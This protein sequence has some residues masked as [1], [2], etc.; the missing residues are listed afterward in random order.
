M[1]T[2]LIL[3]GIA[4]AQALAVIGVWVWTGVDTAPEVRDLL[5]LSPLAIEEIGIRSI[6][7]GVV[8]TADQTQTPMS[9]SAWAAATPPRIMLLCIM[10]PCATRGVGVLEARAAA[11]GAAARAVTR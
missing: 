3:G 9:A 5:P 11:A 10:A 6:V 1:Q 2:N 4:A 8:S 7:S